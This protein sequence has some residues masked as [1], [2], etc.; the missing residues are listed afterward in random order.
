MAAIVG[1]LAQTFFIDSKAVNTAKNIFLTSI[2]LYFRNKP[3]TQSTSSGLANPGVTL[4]ICETK[5]Q[6]GIQ[7]PDLFRPVAYGRSR[8]EFGSISTSLNGATATNFTFTRTPLNTNQ[9][10]ALVIKFDGFD[11]GFSLWRNKG[12]EGYDGIEGQ[13]DDAAAIGL[14]NNTSA[15]VS[16]GSNSPN[17]TKGAL[18]GYFFVL[19]SGAV[20]TPQLDVDLKFKLNI[21]TF[22]T[23]S[24]TTYNIINRSY[25][26][27]PYVTTSLTGA[28][29]GGEYVFANST[30]PSGQTISVSTTSA[31]V[32][33]TGTTFLS[34]YTANSLI[35]LKS[36]DDHAVRKIVSISNNSN[37][38]LDYKSP[39]TNSSAQYVLGAIGKVDR[40][41][42]ENS[43]A[44]LVASTANATYNF[45]S[46]ASSDTIVGVTSNATAVIDN[47][48][49]YPVD[50]TQLAQLGAFVLDEFLPDL[51]YTIPPGTYANTTVKLA[52]ED[53]DTSIQEYPVTPGKKKRFTYFPAFMY[54]RS[55]ELAYGDG[56]VGTL[57]NG[58]SI[59]FNVTLSTENRFSSPF[60]DEQDLNF[61]GYQRIINNTL[62]DEHTNSG[63]AIAKYISRRVELAPGQDSEDIRVYAT[64]YRPY[65]TNID[66]YVKFYN[67][68]DPE[69]FDEKSWTRLENVTPATTYSSTENLN[70]YIELEYQLPTLPIYEFEPLSTGVLQ[71]GVFEGQNSNN[72]LVG[73]SGVVNTTIATS[74]LVRIYNP[75]FPNNSLIS[76]VTASN[77]TTFTIDTTLSSANTRLN[78]FVRAGNLVEKVE[79]KNVAFKNFTANGVVRYYNSEMSAFDTYTSFAIKVI[80]RAS[81]ASLVYPHLKDIR[82]IA[83]SV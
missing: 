23:T 60:I 42:P 21:G 62:V 1:D 17:M 11:T 24:N 83:L 41:L 30:I 53:Y 31:N 58:K 37:L 3:T 29:Q 55:D 18:D 77:T 43:M 6:D 13:T 78:D 22:S 44:I 39:F 8:K 56:S 69:L 51:K 74:D 57:V 10:Y 40:F 25:E 71:S 32:T 65:G 68:F 14:T 28:F 81:T 70:D 45:I 63:Q 67:E 36:G 12:N 4:Y 35:I 72:V 82:A 7:V 16:R 76:V 52:N 61:F 80:F 15:S 48:L 79:F 38:V 50:Q 59:N 20:A 73:T 33:G 9:T 5:L 34:T 49:E 64:A 2:D 19:T 27:I 54:S 47:N 66:V 46:N 26:M 75:L